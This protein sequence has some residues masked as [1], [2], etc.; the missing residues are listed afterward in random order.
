MEPIGLLHMATAMP[1]MP[2]AG[3]RDAWPTYDNAAA[4]DQDAQQ[5]ALNI[6]ARCP[7]LE[8]CKRRWYESLDPADHPRGVVGGVIVPPKRK[9]G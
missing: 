3:C 5:A 9:A 6:C 8:P 2:N 4:G 7:H 1:D